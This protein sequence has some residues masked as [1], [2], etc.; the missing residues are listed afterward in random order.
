V[1]K[2]LIVDDDV[3]MTELLKTLFQLEGYMPT[4]VNDSTKAIQMAGSVGPD[5]ITLDLMMPGLDGFGLCEL[6]QQDSRF[7]N[8]PILIISAR[9]DPESK[10]RAMKAGAKAYVTKPFQIDELMQKIRNLISA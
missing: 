4:A 8:V 5:L 2:I 3:K 10:Q 7:A 1:S 9:D 6:L